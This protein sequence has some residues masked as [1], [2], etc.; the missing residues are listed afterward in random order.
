MGHFGH[1]QRTGRKELISVGMP[2]DQPNAGKSTNLSFGGMYRR[3]AG[4][5]AS[6]MREERWTSR[7]RSRE[8]HPRQM[9]C[10]LSRANGEMIDSDEAKQV[11]YAEDGGG[12]GVYL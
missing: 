3:H 6:W 2:P 7:L 11:I 10:W 5:F 8:S 4:P 12:R 1:L 9:T